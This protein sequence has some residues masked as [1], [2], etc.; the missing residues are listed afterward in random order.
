MGWRNTFVETFLPLIAHGA[1]SHAD[2]PADPDSIFVLRNNDIGDLLVVTP[3]FEA[4]KRLYPRATLAVGIGDWNRAVL[5]NNPWVSKVVSVNAPWHNKVVADQSP[6]AALR[7]LYGSPEMARLRASRFQIGIDVLGSQWGACLLCRAGIPY[8]VGVRGYAGGHSIMQAAVQYRAEEH[9]GRSALRL[10]ELLGASDLPTIRPQ[11]F[12]TDAEHEA[13]KSRWSSTPRGRR[14]I[15]APGGGF[16]AKCWPQESFRAL[17]KGL[18]EHQAAEPVVIG[19]DQDRA[20]GQVL[21]AA[22]ARNWV[23][24]MDLRQVFAV[25]AQSDFVIANSSMAMHAAAA[26]EIPTVVVLGEYYASAEAHARQWGYA[27]N[28]CNLG[29]DSLHPGLFTAAEALGVILPKLKALTG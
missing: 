28:W 18:R 13:A 14:V 22:G 26:F 23:G 21:E 5:E 10:A 24:Q 17:V 29:K 20:E 3:L 6:L 15:V 4:L 12:L 27:G 16:Q 19:S 25:I 7:Y 11:L 9:V 8:R 1:P 2:R